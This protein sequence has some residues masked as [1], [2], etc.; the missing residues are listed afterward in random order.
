LSRKQFPPRVPDLWLQK[1]NKWHT[2]LAL[3]QTI[4]INK[5]KIKY[6]NICL[7]HSQTK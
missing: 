6:R 4:H 1:Q 2:H 5:I 3:H 7:F